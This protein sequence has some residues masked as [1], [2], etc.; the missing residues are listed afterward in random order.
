MWPDVAVLIPTYNRAAIVVQTIALLRKNLRYSGR[1]SYYV[2]IDGDG[3]DSSSAL[4]ESGVSLLTPP[5]GS[6]GAN[7]NR[8][9][10]AAGVAGREFYLELDDDHW[11]MNPLKLDEHVAKLRDDVTTGWIHL[12]VDAVGD[13]DNDGYCFTA[14]LDGKH[15]RLNYDSPDQWPCSFRAHLSH[16][17]FHQKVGAFQEGVPS[18]RCEWEFNQR[19]KRM[20][21]E[22][23]LPD[24]LVP[25]CAYGFQ[26]WAHVGQ[27]WNRRGL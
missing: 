24:I 16:R 17:R 8:L 13:E 1:I 7:L 21:I 4:S 23:K 19:A 15:W 22:G 2:G 27:S 11:L 26:H 18:G 25:L 5:T 6:L 9:Y 3:D 14:H 20:G 10:R 12:L